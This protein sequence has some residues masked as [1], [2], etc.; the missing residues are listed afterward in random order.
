MEQNG[1]KLRSPLLILA[2][3]L[4]GGMVLFIVVIVLPLVFFLGDDDSVS[5]TPRQVH[6]REVSIP[7]GSGAEAPDFFDDLETDD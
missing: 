4:G 7:A 2:A 6:G 1:A 5:Y 3:V